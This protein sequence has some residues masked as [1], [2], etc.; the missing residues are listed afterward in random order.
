MTLRGYDCHRAW[1]VSVGAV[2][3]IAAL[4]RVS[5]VAAQHS[6]AA[7]GVYGARHGLG[8]E[9]TAVIHEWAGL[10]VRY[11]GFDL[12]AEKAAWIGAR[13][14]LVSTPD[15]KAYLLPMA[16]SHYCY[17][18]DLGGT[19]SG[20]GFDAEWKKAGA[21][22]SGFEFLM[23][24]SDP[25]SIGAETGYRFVDAG[26]RSRWAFAATVRYHLFPRR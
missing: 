13:V 9:G 1:K 18:N 14:D 24:E 3:L 6:S 11:E 10:V 4:A 12:A 20:C 26:S 17:P 2:P 22:M 8:I 16:G 19:G 7:I 5:P 25:W 23:G 21:V 15:T